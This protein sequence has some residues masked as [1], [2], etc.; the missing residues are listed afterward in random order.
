[1]SAHHKPPREALG[2]RSPAIEGVTPGSTDHLLL[3]ALRGPGG[4]RSEQVRARFSTAGPALHRLK[5]A[6]LIN[7]PEHGQK[8]MQISLTQRGRELTE[9]NGPLARAQSLFTYCQL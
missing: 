4:M 6:G 5:T 9:A 3:L 1:M 8:G 7:L 2:S